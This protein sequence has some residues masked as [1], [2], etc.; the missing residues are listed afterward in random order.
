MNNKSSLLAH[1]ALFA[2]QLLYGANFTIAKEVMPNYIL[3]KGIIFMRISFGMLAFWIM[4]WL[5][6]KA[7]DVSK[8]DIPVLILC[9]LLGAAI[10]QIFFF[11]GLNW[12]KPI[13]A[14][15]IMLIVP[16][17]VFVGAVLFFKETYRKI[18]IVGIII[19][20]LGAGLLIGYGRE[21]N[22]SQDG[23]KGDIYV[24]VNAVSYSIY[25]LLARPLLLKYHPVVV[26]KWV[27]SF[28]F[29]FSLPF[30]YPD[31]IVTDWQAIPTSIWIAV[32]YILL[33]TTFLAYLFNAF[34]LTT[35]SPK[36]V[37][38]YI[39]L[40]PILAVL[41]AILAGKDQLTSIKIFTGVL[42]FAGVYLA[43]LRKKIG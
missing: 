8:K 20:C 40:Q 7:K 15:I 38:A 10:N 2:V 12:T 43:S 41:I 22:F 29:L 13:N 30:T 26:M 21:I 34:A 35:L 1:F 23:L 4:H 39:Y 17:I 16:I 33:G 11:V 36:V 27:F 24:L 3:P 19:G 9:G 18:N 5:F 14:S 25:L 31:F 28:G 37:G 32:A 42:I 6:I